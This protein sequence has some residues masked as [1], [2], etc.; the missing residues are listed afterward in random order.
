L[1]VEPVRLGEFGRICGA[2]DAATNACADPAQHRLAVKRQLDDLVVAG[3][4]DE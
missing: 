3:V 2:V 4:C 1:A